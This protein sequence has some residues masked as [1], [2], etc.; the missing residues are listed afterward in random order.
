[1]RNSRTEAV[2]DLRGNQQVQDDVIFTCP[3]CSPHPPDR[4]EELEE[5]NTNRYEHYLTDF[6]D[7]S[8][9][10]EHLRDRIKF[11]GKG[12]PTAQV[13]S[14]LMSIDSTIDWWFRAKEVRA[15]KG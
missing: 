15:N 10:R 11:L 7:A 12:K 13:E 5:Y 14:E 9:L 8:L 3:Y 1:M 6:R 4:G 2:N